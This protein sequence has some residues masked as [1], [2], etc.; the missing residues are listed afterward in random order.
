[1][2]MVASFVM[3]VMQIGI[4]L[5]YIGAG[6]WLFHAGRPGAA[7][8]TLVWGFIANNVIDSVARPYVISRG[9]GLPMSV[10]FLGAMGGLIVWGFIGVF[11]GPT[12]LGLTWTLLRVWLASPPVVSDDPGL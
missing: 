5:V 10:I 8:F 4:H 1:M 6:A 12:L 11:V 9:T 2:L 3:D 7:V